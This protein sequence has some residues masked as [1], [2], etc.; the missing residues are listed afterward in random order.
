MPSITC[1][2]HPPRPI[3]DA[4]VSR[5]KGLTALE[6]VMHASLLII[7]LAL[8]YRSW[9]MLFHVQ[10]VSTDVSFCSGL[11]ISASLVRNY[12]DNLVYPEITAVPFLFS[13]VA[14]L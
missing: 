7:F 12:V 2:S 9:Y 5:Y 4:S 6:S 10:S 11:P 1:N 8:S 14:C 3:V 13:V